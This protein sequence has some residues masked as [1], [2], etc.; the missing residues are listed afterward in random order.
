MASNA[1]SLK[2]TTE[3]CRNI[4]QPLKKKN[5]IEYVVLL[6]NVYH[7]VSKINRLN[8]FQIHFHLPILSAWYHMH[9]KSVFSLPKVV[10]F[11][12]GYHFLLCLPEFTNLLQ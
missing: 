4:R 11:H 9:G 12:I 5:H 6:K 3:H 2:C 10:N 7:K 1:G 8:K